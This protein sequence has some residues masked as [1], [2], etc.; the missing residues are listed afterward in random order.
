[1]DGQIGLTDP[2]MFGLTHRSLGQLLRP[3]GGRVGAVWHAKLSVPQ[4][5]TCFGPMTS[6]VHTLFSYGLSPIIYWILMALTAQPVAAP[7]F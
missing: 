1:M 4:G 2:Y 5:S 3:A 6:H 7:S